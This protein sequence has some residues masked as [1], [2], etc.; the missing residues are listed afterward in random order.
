MCYLRKSTAANDS[1]RIGDDIADAV[2][3]LN[4][5]DGWTGDLGGTDD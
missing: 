2:N 4:P 3:C 5:I 1:N